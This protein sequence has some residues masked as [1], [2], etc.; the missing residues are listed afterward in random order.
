M[1][2][3]QVQK[4]QLGIFCVLKSTTKSKI[5]YEIN[6]ILFEN[7]VFIVFYQKLLAI[8]VYINKNI[9]KT[10]SRSQG[11]VEAN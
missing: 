11:P 6:K 3:L 9:A 1:Y 8:K 5:W 2:E 4:I 10:Q 7:P